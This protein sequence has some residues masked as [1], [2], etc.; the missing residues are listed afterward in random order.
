M[1]RPRQPEVRIAVWAARVSVVANTAIL[2]RAKIARGRK[3]AHT[4]DMVVE[5]NQQI[6]R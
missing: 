6:S 4:K 5:G 1:M 3:V 2:Q